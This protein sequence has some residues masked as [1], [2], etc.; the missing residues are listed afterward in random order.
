MKKSKINRITILLGDK[1]RKMRSV[2]C[3]IVDRAIS[4]P[5][6]ARLSAEVS[7]VFSSLSPPRTVVRVLRK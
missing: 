3:F 5:L 4:L 7:S 1:S 2:Q 6:T